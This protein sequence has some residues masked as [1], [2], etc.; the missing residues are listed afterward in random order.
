MNI[1]VIPQAY[2]TKRKNVTPFI[3]ENTEQLS[4]NGNDVAVLNVEML[5]LKEWHLSKEKNV[6]EHL[7]HN[8]RILHTYMRYIRGAERI[9]TLLFL[10]K[11]RL[12]YELYKTKYGK[13]DI[14]ISHF[15]QYAGYCA[16]II[17]EEDNVP[18]I[19]I[20]H[21]GWLLK[22]DISSYEKN[23][24]IHTISHT[25]KMVCVSDIL[26]EAI[27]NIVGNT[28]RLVVIPNM[29]AN[30]FVYHE[31][32]SKNEYVFFSAA[33]LYSGKRIDLLVESFCKAFSQHENV[34]LRI[35]GDGDQYNKIKLLIS[36]NGRDNQIVLLGSLNKEQM[37]E[38]YI[39]CDCFVLPSEHETFGIV[40]R[41]A[42]A[43]GRPIITT[44]HQGFFGN[45]WCDFYGL[46][47]PIDNEEEL[48]NALI[49]MKNDSC[50][51]DNKRISSQCIANYSCDVILDK[52][53]SLINEALSI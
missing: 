3:R 7:E 48:I 35:A 24:L 27:L 40:Y 45:L 30:S 34:R 38:E 4:L 28:N 52:Y 13:P 23:K 21:A 46:R 5:P 53:L 41:E 6:S 15:S 20:E 36:R 44:D 37:K 47:I 39:F 2:P 8:I 43:I 26:R 19:C 12:M 10:K 11:T 25:F 42:M 14:I 32:V 31:L 9:N 51:Y 1:L 18:H 29:I 49:K 22:G 50:F 16:S 17:S 33:N